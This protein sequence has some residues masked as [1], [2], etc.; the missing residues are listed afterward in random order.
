MK[1]I[2]NNRIL[3]IGKQGN[4]QII[5]LNEYEEFYSF[6]KDTNITCADVSAS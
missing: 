3:V 6:K 5:N 4:I 1:F 2:K